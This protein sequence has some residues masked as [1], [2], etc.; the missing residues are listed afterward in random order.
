MIARSSAEIEGVPNVRIHQKKLVATICGHETEPKG[1]VRAF[2]VECE[3][4]MPTKP[5]GSVEF[6]LDCIAGMT[7][8]CAWCG[9][10]IFIGSPVTLYGAS[11][12]DFVPKPDS[13]VYDEA[14]RQYVGCLGWECADTGAD[15]AGFWVPD[16][17]T[18]RGMVERVRSPIEVAM[19]TGS[20]VLV[21]DLGDIK[22]ARNP[23]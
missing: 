18:R 10:V 17:Q 9:N 8:R 3:M 6:C 13:V 20:T 23:H 19:S 12:P 11:D 4:D 2:D 15:R 14:R 1:Q 5:D 7:I 21:S 16:T 22:E